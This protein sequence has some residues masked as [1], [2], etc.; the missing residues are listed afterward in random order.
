MKRRD[1]QAW[2]DHSDRPLLSDGAMG[3]MLHSHGVP[4]DRCFDH[5]NLTNP[6]AVADIH[7]AYV[8]A[9]AEIILTNT[10]GANRYKLAD[11]GLQLD[12]VPIN[13]AG[14]ALAR[15]VIE[16]ENKAVLLAGDIGP[17]GV[18]MVPFGRVTRDQAYAAFREQAQALVDAG[19]DLL[20]IETMTDL[21]EL[22]SA[23]RAARSLSD[24]PII[25]SMTFTRDDRT[26]LGESPAR[27][28]GELSKVDVDVV[29]VNCSGG[30]A[31]LLRIARQM[32]EKIPDIKLWVKP[33]AGWP[34]QIA[35]RIMYPA[36][37]EYFAESTWS[38]QDAGVSIIGG[39]CGTTPDHISAIRRAID[40]GPPPD[41]IIQEHLERPTH[42]GSELSPDHPSSLSQQLPQGHFI[43][44]VEMDPP[45]GLST[46]RLL[47]GAGLLAETGADVINV[48]DS[49][50]ARMRMSPWAV[51]ALLQDKV[52]IETT[53][54]FPTRG[55]SLLRVQGDL[56]AAHA[57]GIRNVFVVMGDPTAIG[58]YP[59]AM[60]DYDVVPSGLI[61]LITKKFNAGVDMSGS[62]IGEPTSFFVGGA[63]NLT[64][65]DPDREIKV[66]RRKVRAG[67]N[68]FLTQPVF[69][70]PAAR[71]FLRRYREK[72]GVLNV[73]I[74][75]GILPLYGAR[76]ANFLHNEVPGI[77][78]DQGII[79][80]LQLADKH[81]PQVGVEISIDLI[82]QMED[83]VQG[84]YLMPAFNRYDLAADIVAA[85]H[86]K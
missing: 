72:Y 29:G 27:V 40:S 15:Q 84:V 75:M 35:G 70:P 19:V 46:H 18:R 80:R 21:V 49:P 37:P 59:D 25:A 56:L 69:N 58:D 45:R 47:A 78:I 9:G 7:R 60:D 57:L 71:A 6:E 36:T 66:L 68:F 77:T 43:F 83:W 28:A 81:A 65:Q 4:F 1:F 14:A 33:N 50:M 73:P 53:L 22:L 86:T 74:L 55:R 32:R 54:H 44:A 31:Q 41:Y 10:F 52:N 34:E 76:H 16:Q 64:P 23:I 30:P 20:V 26:L 48:A 63:L 3:T 12:V 5:L 61:E 11:H 2:L 85:F 39:C 67:V 42:M 24:K 38:L 79:D 51:C 8:A 62:D 17:L 13:Q 82:H